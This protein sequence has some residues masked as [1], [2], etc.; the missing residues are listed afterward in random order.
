MKAAMQIRL[1]RVSATSH[2]EWTRY[3]H[4]AKAQITLTSTSLIKYIFQDRYIAKSG[5][6]IQRKM[7]SPPLVEILRREEM[8]IF[9]THPQDLFHVHCTTALR[10]PS[11][12]PPSDTKIKINGDGIWHAPPSG[13]RVCQD[14]NINSTHSIQR[15]QEHAETCAGAFTMSFA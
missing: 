6:H 13:V 10:A 12:V 1:R 9:C 14:H 5:R 4:R 8:D 7:N 3:A 15:F 11:T 2:G